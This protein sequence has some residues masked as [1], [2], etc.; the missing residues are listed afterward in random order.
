ME[1]FWECLKEDGAMNYV[2]FA[3]RA[4]DYQV[5]HENDDTYTIC[6]RKPK[7]EGGDEIIGECPTLEAMLD[8]EA[9]EGVKLRDIFEQIPVKDFLWM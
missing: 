9:I 7:A 6:H 1:I 2:D 8:S 3:F 5:I 4:K